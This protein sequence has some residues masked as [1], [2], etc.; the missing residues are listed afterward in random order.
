M[1]RLKTV[2]RMVLQMVQM[3]QMVQMWLSK[4]PVTE[5]Q[6]QILLVGEP[7]CLSKYLVA[8]YL[9]ALFLVASPLKQDCVELIGSRYLR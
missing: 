2:L 6:S 9:A 1:E 4:K 7:M 8:L 3:V 5:C